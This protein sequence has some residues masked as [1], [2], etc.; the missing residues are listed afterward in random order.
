[1]NFLNVNAAGTCIGCGGV[2]APSLGRKGDFGTFLERACNGEEA[3]AD[4]PQASTGELP[5]E[6]FSLPPWFAD[7]MPGKGIPL[8]LS[9]AR[10]AMALTRDGEMSHQDRMDLEAFK[11]KNA[12]HQAFLAQ[13]RFQRQ[14]ADEIS[15]YQTTLDRMFQD[16]LDRFGITDQRAYYEKLILDPVTSEAVH[17]EVKAGLETDER[18]MALAKVLGTVV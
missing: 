3:G 9:V 4:S 17:Q 2:A 1:M 11:Q 6:A 16:V 13:G 12:A 10:Y 14:Y 8:D 15:E 7:M 18:F 5:L